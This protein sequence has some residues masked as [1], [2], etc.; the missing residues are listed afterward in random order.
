MTDSATTKTSSPTETKIHEAHELAEYSGGYITERH[1]TIPVWL[2][3]VYAVLF[4]WS[5]YYL[6]NVWG[7]HGPVRIG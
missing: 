7:G 4:L 6:V 1:G 5:L 3:V 2:L